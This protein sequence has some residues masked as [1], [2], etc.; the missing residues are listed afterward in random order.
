MKS[1]G[2]CLE[3]PLNTQ[4]LMHSK[5]ERIAFQVGETLRIVRVFY[6]FSCLCMHGELYLLDKKY[7]YCFYELM[8]LNEC[9]YFL[10]LAYMVFVN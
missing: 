9:S 6:T 8:I 5:Q 10:C 3:K 4:S 1:D 7:Q 2:F